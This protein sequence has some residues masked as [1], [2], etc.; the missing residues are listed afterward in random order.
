MAFFITERCNGCTACRQICPTHAISGEKTQQHRIFDPACIDCGACGRVCPAGAVVNAFGRQV[1]KIPRKKWARPLFDLAR[2]VSCRI[3]IDACPTHAL[4]TVLQ[5]VGDLHPYPWLAR[6][7]DCM[8]CGFCA[9]D[10]P[11]NAVTLERTESASA[12]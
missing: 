4:E 2:C 11:V 9:A 7:P 3:C 10:C 5:K 1:S 12:S 8:A 6:E